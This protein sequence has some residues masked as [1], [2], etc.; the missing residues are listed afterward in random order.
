MAEED[1]EAQ[2]AASRLMWQR[3]A[4]CQEGGVGGDTR[5]K[6]RAHALFCREM[7]AGL[8]TKGGRLQADQG[9][10]CRIEAPLEEAFALMTSGAARS[11]AGKRTD[12]V[13]R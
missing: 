2:G 7:V 1:P 9:A 5:T 8:Q 6:Y 13:V 10:R 4:G 11:Q 3:V 12:V